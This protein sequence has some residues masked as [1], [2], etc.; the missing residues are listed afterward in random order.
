MYCVGIITGLTGAAGTLGGIIFTL[1]SRY[2]GTSYGRFMSIT[3]IV[4]ISLNV[5]VAWIRP[6][7]K[8][9]LGGR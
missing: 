7:P 2:S 1:I 3:G 8:G 9:Q 6:V 5:L 4:V